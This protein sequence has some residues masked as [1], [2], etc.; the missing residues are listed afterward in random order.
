MEKV[1]TAIALIV[2]AY[3][4]FEMR[5]KVVYYDRLVW[6]VV[7]SNRQLYFAETTHLI[8]QVYA[9]QRIYTK[10]SCTISASFSSGRWFSVYIIVIDWKKFALNVASDNVLVVEWGEVMAWHI[11][12]ELSRWCRVFVTNWVTWVERR[13]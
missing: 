2:R 6:C 3:C 1:A 4:F 13:A 12:V 8:L 7:G 9:S 10:A 11:I 5:V